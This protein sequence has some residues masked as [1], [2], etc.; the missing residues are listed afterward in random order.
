[1]IFDIIIL[2]FRRQKG[3]DRYSQAAAEIRNPFV[4]IA[5]SPRDDV[6]GFWVRATQNDAFFSVEYLTI[7]G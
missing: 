4:A 6:T 7:I 2:V 1:M 5:G 3:G